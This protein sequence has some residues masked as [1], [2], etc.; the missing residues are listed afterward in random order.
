[1][2]YDLTHRFISALDDDFNVAKA[3]AALFEFIRHAHRT[4]D[5]HGL[6][7]EDKGKIED[8]LQKIDSVLG[9]LDLEDAK[10]DQEIEAL[11][12]KRASARS[13]K[14]WRSADSIRQE[15][16]AKGIELIDTKTSTVWH[17]KTD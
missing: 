14:D 4:M 17:K 11:I 13:R 12:R 8:V 9:V 6:S 1:L 7:A 15:L 16:A 2:V 3:L 5:T 10:M